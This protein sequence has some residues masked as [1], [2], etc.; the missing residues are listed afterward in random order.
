MAKAPERWVR[1]IPCL[2]HPEASRKAASHGA[3]GSALVFGVL[4]GLVLPPPDR[5][6]EDVAE[7][8]A[9][10]DRAEFGHRPLLLIDL[11]RLDRKR[12]PPGGA[13]DGG[14]LGVDAL[15]DREAIG[16]L[17]ATVAR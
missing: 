10:F 3:P 13:I 17:L 2:T 9:G 15:A 12:D 4:L 11:A 1:R 8:G 16:S 7:A 14:D 5:R 6:A